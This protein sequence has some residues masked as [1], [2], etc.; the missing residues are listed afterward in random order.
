M[1]GLA[2]KLCLSQGDA[3]TQLSDILPGLIDK[4]TPQSQAPASGL[5]N[6][7]DLAGMLTG[8]SQKR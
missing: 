7:G 8:L 6:A 2:R 3:A 4:L 5:G 1:A